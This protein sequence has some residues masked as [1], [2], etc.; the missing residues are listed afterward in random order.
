MRGERPTA[1]L[2]LLK[3]HV[4]NAG[5][6]QRIIGR[7]YGDQPREAGDVPE[8]KDTGDAEFSC[9]KEHGRFVFVTQKRLHSDRNFQVYSK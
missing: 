7:G 5:F 2:P 9:G 8:N 1:A 3:T 4:S 6:E